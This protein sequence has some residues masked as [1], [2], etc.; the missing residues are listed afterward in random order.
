MRKT[1]W[2]RLRD[3]TGTI[4]VLLSTAAGVLAA[5]FVLAKTGRRVSLSEILFGLVM[6]GVIVGKDELRESEYSGKRARFINRMIIAFSH[7]VAYQTI[8]YGA[9][10]SAGL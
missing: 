8:G 4:F 10:K 7:G 9:G 1:L 2:N 6:A 3:G 5:N